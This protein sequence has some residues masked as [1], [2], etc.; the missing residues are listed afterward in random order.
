MGLFLHPRWFP[1]KPKF[2]NLDE[3]QFVNVSLL[4]CFFGVISKTYCQN[5]VAKDY[6]Y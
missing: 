4:T 5:Q 2:S 1:L 6:F 3:L